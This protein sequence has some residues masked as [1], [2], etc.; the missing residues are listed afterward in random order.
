[1]KRFAILLP[2]IIL[3]GWVATVPN[4]YSCT[5][6]CLKNA[7]G[8]VAGF[9]HD[10]LIKDALIMT[11][12]RG[13]SKIAAPP[14]NETSKESLAKW[15]SKYGSVT[16]NQSGQGFPS[17]GMN[18]K[19]L[20]V[21]ILLL[22]KTKWPAPDSQTSISAGQWIQYQLDNSSNVQE[23]IAN[24]KNIQIIEG[25]PRNMSGFHFMACDRGGECVTVE[26][27]DGKTVYHMQK[28]LPVRVLTNT[29]YAEAI[30]SLKHGKPIYGDVYHSETRFIQ[31]SNR[32]KEAAIHVPKSA[33]N[34]AFETLKKV[35]SH[36]VI[37]PTVWSIVYDLANLRVSFKTHDNPQ[38][39]YFDFSAFDFSCASSGKIFDILSESAGDVSGKFV[40]YS[41]QANKKLIMK[42]WSQTPGLSDLP[43]ELLD[44]AAAYPE[45]F[46]CTE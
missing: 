15:T 4:S 29:P 9:N 1:M 28:N 35:E 6:I 45:S 30:N 33:T 38:I 14:N 19:G 34:F 26:A 27:I 7:K 46:V 32:L 17:D 20:F 43:G 3:I 5:A 31:A 16:F 40:P 12:R 2:L 42:T 41:H 37:G 25:S 10:W 36:D 39:R 21:A 23:V 11:N 8:W 24:D 22:E 18:E 44:R 13:L